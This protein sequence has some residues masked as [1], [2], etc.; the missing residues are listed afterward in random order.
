MERQNLDRIVLYGIGVT[1]NTY[2]KTL[3]IVPNLTGHLKILC[4][5]YVGVN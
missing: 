3:Y 2:V 4:I 5:M 1:C